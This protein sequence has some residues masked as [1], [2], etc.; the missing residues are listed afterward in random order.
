MPRQA[1]ELQRS[2]DDAL[3]DLSEPDADAVLEA[4][5]AGF[6]L[7]AYADGKVTQEE[8]LRVR[9]IIPRFATLRFLPQ[10]DLTQAFE[11]ATGWFESGPADA[12]RRALDLI[13]R[14]GRDQ[15][16]GIPL[17]RACHAIATADQ[18]FDAS[19]REAL[20]SICGALN[21]NPADYGLKQPA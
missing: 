13:R 1:N 7:V 20:I 15:K 2:I 18:A 5:M 4:V 10:R 6:A 3:I 12:K 11:T 19:E 9:S 17:L 16:V 21:L 8:R 14:V